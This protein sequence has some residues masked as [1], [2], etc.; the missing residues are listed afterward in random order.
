V[1]TLLHN[2]VFFSDRL[3]RRHRKNLISLL[4]P[5]KEVSDLYV[6]FTQ[7]ELDYFGRVENLYSGHK[8]V[9]NSTNPLKWQG[10]VKEVDL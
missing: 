1:S 5:F 6:P 9:T 10:W 3:T 2:C 7:P 8:N 4:I